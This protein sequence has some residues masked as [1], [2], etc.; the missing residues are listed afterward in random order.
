MKVVRIHSFVIFIKR[1]DERNMHNPKIV[2]FTEDINEAF[3]HISINSALDGVIDRR[4]APLHLK[5]DVE[6]PFRIG[7]EV[8]PV[9]DKHVIA[10]GFIA[11][12]H[13]LLE[14]W[15]VLW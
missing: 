15:Y 12:I 7:I 2:M 6:E 14:G 11:M 13:C 1:H 5:E 3:T 9:G 4:N 10:N 8:L